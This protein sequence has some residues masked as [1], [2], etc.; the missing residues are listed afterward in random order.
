MYN[1]KPAYLIYELKSLT[2]TS[3]VVKWVWGR[4]SEC[5]RYVHE[6]CCQFFWSISLCS[7]SKFLLQSEIRKNYKELAFI[8][9]IPAME[10]ADTS[11][12]NNPTPLVWARS[13]HNVLVF[14]WHQLLHCSGVYSQSFRRGWP[15]GF[16]VFLTVLFVILL[17]CLV[18]V[19]LCFISKTVYFF[20]IFLV[21]V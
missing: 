19:L 5:S 3:S 12:C 15:H 1:G 11:T 7:K 14:A 10:V 20:L 2:I 9:R 17:S 8:K 18:H 4:L 13:G 21:S 6:F 16:R